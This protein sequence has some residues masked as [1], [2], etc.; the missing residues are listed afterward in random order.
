MVLL[1]KRVRVMDKA[2]VNVQV[3]HCNEPFRVK[4]QR[5]VTSTKGVDVAAGGPVREAVGA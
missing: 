4:P 3:V 5:T 1:P 2:V